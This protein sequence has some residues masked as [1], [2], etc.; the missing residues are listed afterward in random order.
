MHADSN[1][2]INAVFKNMMIHPVKV[3]T[4]INK[5]LQKGTTWKNDERKLTLARTRWKINFNLK[6]LSMFPLKVQLFWDC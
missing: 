3:E 5:W 4:S 6:C 2:L 1:Y